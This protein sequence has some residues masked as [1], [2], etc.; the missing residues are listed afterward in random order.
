[1]K[2]RFTALSLLV[3]LLLGI[4]LEFSDLKE[5]FEIDNISIIP[6]EFGIPKQPHEPVQ[7]YPMNQVG[8]SDMANVGTSSINPARLN[9]SGTNFH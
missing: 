5:Q 7:Q 8:M 1:M 9:S 2:Y 6:F 4:A 3:I